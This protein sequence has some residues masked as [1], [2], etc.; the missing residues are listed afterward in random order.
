MSTERRQNFSAIPGV[1]NGIKSF[2]PG[3]SGNIKGGVGSGAKKLV[4]KNFRSRPT[5][6]ENFQTKSLDK[7]RRAVVAIQV[8]VVSNMVF[9]NL[10]VSFSYSGTYYKPAFSLHTAFSYFVLICDVIKIH[11]FVFALTHCAFDS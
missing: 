6:P 10:F 4:I 3:T 2:S 8:R 11:T 9:R 5:L 1:N 7:L